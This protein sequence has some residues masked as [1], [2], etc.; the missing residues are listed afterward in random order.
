MPIYIIIHYA[1]K[2][3]TFLKIHSFPEICSIIDSTELFLVIIPLRNLSHTGPWSLIP[4]RRATTSIIHT[5]SP[6]AL[7]CV[8]R[9]T[10]V[11]VFFY[12]KCFGLKFS[13]VFLKHFSAI[14][15]LAV[16]S[17]WLDVI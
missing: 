2:D 15:A 9:F 10:S 5:H 12:F 14:S 4:D 8:W 7:A 16:K 11:C 3:Y 6:V 17:L 13:D 1:S